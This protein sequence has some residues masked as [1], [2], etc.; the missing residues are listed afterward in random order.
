MRRVMSIWFPQLPFDRRVR[1]GDPRAQGPFVITSETQ[2]ALRVTHLS[3]AARSAGLTAGQSLPDARAICPDVLTEKSDPARDELL[4]R[5]LWRW[6]DKLSPWV[7]L[8]PP[9]GLFLDIT[10]CAHLFGGEIEMGEYSLMQFSNMQITSRIGIADTKRAAWALA[11]FTGEKVAVAKRGNSY[12]ALKNLPLESLNIGPQTLKD[13]RRTGLKKVGDLY[14]RK[15]SELARRFGLELTDRLSHAMGYS[16]DPVSPQTADPVYAARMTLPEPIGFLSD[17]NTVLG[18]LSSS[19]CTRLE[20]DQKGARRF[21]LTVRCVDTGNHDLS[22][23]FARPCFK[24]RA[25]QQQFARPLDGLKIKYGADWFRLVANNIE[26]L[27]PRQLIFGEAQKRADED[28]DQM[29]STLGNRLGFDRIRKF[30]PQDSH[31][32][33]QAFSSIEAVL[34]E[35]KNWSLDVRERPFRLFTRPERLRTLRA[36]RP[37]KAF[38]WRRTAFETISAK[39]P[40][41]LTPD[42]WRCSD[43]RMRDYWITGTTCGLKLWLMTYPAG[44]VPEWFVAGR[45][46]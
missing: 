40:E 20:K 3:E 1:M 36:G 44:D 6:S 14:G 29:L 26:P 41:R 30:V 8:D 21:N 39:G 4:L 16:P 35:S 7:A 33:E 27:Q 37:P 43:T 13:L 12:A 22:V 23:G 34:S 46:T 18:K 11:R 31:M 38:E 15:S 5:A 2:N 45:F 9:S 32:P 10:G 19:V 28:F 42:W 25:V 17:L 24:A